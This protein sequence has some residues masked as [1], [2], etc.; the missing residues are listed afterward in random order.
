MRSLA[1]SVSSITITLARPV[2]FFVAILLLMSIVA[3]SGSDGTT[4]AASQ[5]S[6]DVSVNKAND[7]A[8]GINDS[9]TSTP[10]DGTQQAFTHK[11]M[12][13]TGE[14][15]FAQLAYEC[16]ECTFQQWE[17]IVAPSGWSKGPAQIALFSAP[18]S[19]MRSY[20]SVE[21]HPDSVDF[22]DEVPGSEYRLIAVT[23]NGKLIENGPNGIVAQAQ[24]QRDTRLVFTKGMRVHELTDAD[25]NVFVLFVHH[26]DKADWQNADFQSENVLDY[27]TA[28]EG[29]TYATRIL[30]EELVLDSNNSDGVVTVLA[31]RGAINS[32]WEK[33]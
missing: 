1:N 6:G 14:N 25:G 8:G 12:K 7:D 22:L 15:P 23:L 30:A 19:I 33:R 29:W 21:G 4:R 3:C 5:G 31:I 26:I 28:P 20:P 9:N 13:Q 27:F 11:M 32:T 16:V 2:W 18:D 24:V 10:P 17:S